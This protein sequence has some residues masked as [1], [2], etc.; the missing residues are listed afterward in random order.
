MTQLAVE[1]GELAA[2]ISLA[3]GRAWP[4]RRWRA[5]FTTPPS[6]QAL[7]RRIFDG[8]DEI[9]DGPVEGVG[10]AT[11]SAP[12]IAGMRYLPETDDGAELLTG[13][14]Q[15]FG[16]PVAFRRA[17]EAAALAE[18]SLG[19][20][21]GAS[22]HVYIHLGREVLCD[23]VTLGNEM[24]GAH[25][26]IGQIGHWRVTEDG[27]RCACG[28]FG[29]L[30]PL[31]SSQGFVRLAIGMVSQ[32][33]NALAA[34]S[35]ASNARVETLSAQRVVELAHAG[36][37]PLRELVDRAADALGVALARLALVVDPSRITLGGPLGVAGLEFIEG[38]RNR[39]TADLHRVWAD[40]P[41][42]EVASA[43]LEPFS[44]LAGAWL[45]AQKASAQSTQ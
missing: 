9:V 4:G 2:W 39:M 33:D 27:P 31:C 28:Q 25:G 7:L 29:H 3:Y 36:V 44:A 32:D 6:P 38:A 18:T 1:I 35:A 11:W 20:G 15:R 30:S 26:L 5:S 16:A 41:A 37:T 14:E 22:P 40:W 45:L 23:I 34:A 43:K 10:V 13:L 42:P 17:V 12:F 8:A 21:E 24:S 19:A